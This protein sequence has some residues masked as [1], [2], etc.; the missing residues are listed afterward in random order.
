ME[1][2]DSPRLGSAVPGRERRGCKDHHGQRAVEVAHLLRGAQHRGGVQAAVARR[3]V[4][5]AEVLRAY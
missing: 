3:V 5:E 2:G 1:S 4:H